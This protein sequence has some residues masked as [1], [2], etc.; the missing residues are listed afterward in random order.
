[1]PDPMDME[2]RISDWVDGTLDESARKQLESEMDSDLDL[3]R[4]AEDFIRIKTLA[5]APIP[6]VPQGLRHRLQAR[7]DQRYGRRKAS[8]FVPLRRFG[9]WGGTV[10]AAATA[11]LFLFWPHPQDSNLARVEQEL[12][13]A[14]SRYFEAV[15]KMTVL[16]EAHL[17]TL[18]PEIA[19]VYEQNLAIIDAAIAEC[20][21]CLDQHPQYLMAYQDL[22]RM[23]EAKT[24]LMRQILAS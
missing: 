12:A 21:Q 6:P 17:Q 22:Q 4:M 18:P 24:A 14:Q 20:R 16:C 10:A 8:V 9:L 15:D 2:Q 19:E 11:V 23:M 3:K 7:V 5:D 13:T 1:M